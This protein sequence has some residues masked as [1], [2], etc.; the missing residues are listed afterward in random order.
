VTSNTA[1]IV[2]DGASNIAT[3]SSRQLGTNLGYWAATDV[4]DPATLAA[5]Q[6]VGAKL[7]RWPGGTNSDNYHW[8][9]HTD[10]D[11]DTGTTPN[12]ATFN[13]VAYQASNTFPNFVSNIL[14]G[15]NL[16][17]VITVDYGTN[18]TCTAG[19][20]P[21]EAAAW[22]AYVKA[23]GYNI[24]YWTV[25]NE[26]FG[27]WEPDLHTSSVPGKSHIGADYVKNVNGANGFYALMKAQDPSAQVGVVVEGAWDGLQDWDGWD[28]AVLG[29]ATVTDANTCATKKTGAKFDFVE[30]HYY[31]QQ[32][33]SPSD[34]AGNGECDSYLLGQAITDFSN[35]IANLRAQLVTTGHSATTPIMLGEFNSV[36]Y[37]QGKQTMSI[38]NALN[39]GMVYGEIFKNQ[40]DITTLWFGAGGNQDCNENNS[41][42]LYGWQ[43]FGGYDEVAYNTSS[44][45]NNCNDSDP[46]HTI[47][48]GTLLPTG[49]AA[50]LVSQ[51]ATP[52]EHILTAAV[53]SSL[54]NVRVYAATQGTGYSLM[55]FNL[56][57]TNTTSATVGISNAPGSSFTGSTL[58]YGKAQYDDSQNYI[59]TGPVSQSLGTVGSTV[60]LSLPPWSM[61]VLKLQ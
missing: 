2:I 57:Q 13:P 25:G 51:F 33:G 20:D 45:W 31:E 15:G 29:C 39:I 60:T 3:I 18:V 8:Q 30:L 19:A 37:N 23:H 42:S 41:D 6:A 36:A 61:T 35:S 16:E 12:T 24:H 27:G 58:T 59:W 34:C 17:G 22:V 56:D 5:V 32:P 14:V 50:Y 48:E 4:T 49:R 44:S 1:Q 43:Q 10:C 28:A 46:T 52:G 55:L 47:P 7:V 9:N 40:V 53:D 21:H 11:T 38:V 26:Q 54:P